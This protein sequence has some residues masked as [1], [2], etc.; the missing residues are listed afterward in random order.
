MGENPPPISL[1]TYYFLK[2]K[3]VPFLK[4]WP[5]TIPCRRKTIKW[6]TKLLIKKKGKGKKESERE[7]S[8]KI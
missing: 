3:F 7:R 4:G 1:Y 5:A 2:I 8:K 6:V